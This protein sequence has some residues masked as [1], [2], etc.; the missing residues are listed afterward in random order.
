M[1]DNQKI[2]DYT[3]LCGHLP[4][5]PIK[6]FKDS[7]GFGWLCDKG[8][9]PSKDFRAQGCWRCDEMAFPAGGR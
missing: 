9:D 4:A 2:E 6:Y 8:I 3:Y 1:A 5:R 7:D